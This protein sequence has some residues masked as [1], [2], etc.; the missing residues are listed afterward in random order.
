MP[1]RQF[2]GPTLEAALEAV[3]AEVGSDA[4]ILGA[5]KVRTGGIAGF[6]AKERF[7]VTVEVGEPEAAADSPS[8]TADRRFQSCLS[9][10]GPWA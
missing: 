7:E 3:R 1:T 9:R 2:D 5:E 6:F 4:K 8:V 10:P